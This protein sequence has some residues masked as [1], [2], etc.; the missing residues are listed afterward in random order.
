M[1]AGKTFSIYCKHHHINTF[2]TRG[3]KCVLYLLFVMSSVEIFST[4]R[5][6]LLKLCKSKTKLIHQLRRNVYK[7]RR[8]TS[9]SLRTK[10]RLLK[11]PIRDNQSNLTV[12]AWAPIM[13]HNNA[14]IGILEL[15]LY[16]ILS[17]C[18]QLNTGQACHF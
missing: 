15:Y 9:R 8:S 3:F 1:Y 13:H 7:I 16:P 12:V 4:S 17:R 18:T 5:M 14:N 6:Q 10:S 2:E 11:Q